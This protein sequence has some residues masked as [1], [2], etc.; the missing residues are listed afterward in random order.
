MANRSTP[1]M[2]RQHSVAKGGSRVDPNE[3]MFAGNATRSI[4]PSGAM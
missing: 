3:A 1:A 2:G 4:S